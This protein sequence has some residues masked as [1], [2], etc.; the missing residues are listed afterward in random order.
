[1]SFLSV[2]VTTRNRAESLCVTLDQLGCQTLDVGKFEVI[3]VD[4]GSTDRTEELVTERMRSG[5]L[6]LRYLRHERRGPGYTSNV[7]IRESRGPWV[8]LLCDDIRP[9][10]ELLEVHFRMHERHPEPRVALAGMVLQ[11][12]DLPDTVFHRN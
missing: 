9:R 6:L 5:P 1:M 8:L 7:G 3:V 10:P 4:D 11:S 2:V 12:P